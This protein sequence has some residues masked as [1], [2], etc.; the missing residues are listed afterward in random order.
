MI[1]EIADKTSISTIYIVW[2]CNDEKPNDEN[3]PISFLFIIFLF[4]IYVIVMPIIIIIAKTM[5]V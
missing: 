5:Q 4:F 1:V 2:I 3:T